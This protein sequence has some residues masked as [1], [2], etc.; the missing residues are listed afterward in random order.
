DPDVYAQLHRD[1]ST[2]EKKKQGFRNL[3]EAGIP[4]G[5]MYGCMS[6]SKPTMKDYRETIDWFV[7]EV[8][9]KNFF[10]SPY[11]P[12]GSFAPT[13]RHLELSLS[14]YREAF[15]YRSEKLGHPELLRMGVSDGVD[16]C[17]THIYIKSDG[18][19]IPCS[20]MREVVC[21]NI[22]EEPLEK[23]LRENRKELLFHYP[24]E[25]YCGEE[26]Y[27]RDVCFGCRANAFHYLGDRRASDP[28][29]WLNPRSCEQEI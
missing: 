12:T 8:G 1:P 20:L 27:N 10:F 28:K 11:K 21:G 22:Y 9:V 5:K 19:V 15:T 3:L 7:D 17:Q 24:V 18:G 26:C 13:H 25:G 16:F 6:L 2:L 23:I 29:C 4:P 14:D